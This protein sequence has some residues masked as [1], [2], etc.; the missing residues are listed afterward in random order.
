LESNEAISEG[1][2]SMKRSREG[3]ISINRREKERNEEIAREIVNKRDLGL[4][5]LA[6]R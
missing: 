4:F 5:V 1:E 3:E 2:I 6:Y